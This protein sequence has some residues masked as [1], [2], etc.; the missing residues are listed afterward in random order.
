[1]SGAVPIRLKIRASVGGK[2][3]TEHFQSCRGPRWRHARLLRAARAL[4]LAL[5]VPSGTPPPDWSPLRTR[6]RW[7]PPTR[8]YRKFDRSSLFSDLAYA[9]SATASYCKEWNLEA[10][11]VETFCGL[12]MALAN[13]C[14]TPEG[15]TVRCTT[16]YQVILQIALCEMQNNSST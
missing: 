12:S 6:R 4:C 1:M 16:F 11:T 8:R 10:Q 5:R 9:C 3:H 13:R 7:H 2:R 15:E 14:V